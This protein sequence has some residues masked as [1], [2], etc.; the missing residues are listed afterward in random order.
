[1]HSD[2]S[3]LPDNDVK[4]RE[5]RSNHIEQ[6][7]A[8]P[9]YYEIT[10]I[11]HNQQP[12]AHRSDRPCLVTYNPTSQIDEKKIIKR[13]W[14]QHV[15]HDVRHMALLIHWFRFIQG[16]QRT[17]HCGAHTLVNSQETCLVSGLATPKQISAD[18]P[19]NDPKA[20]RSFNYYGSIMYRSD[21]NRA[22]AESP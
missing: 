5:T 10:Y 6:Y 17:W 4:P 12:W 11:M 15:V 3:V 22:T 7:G 21:F 1:M 8:R 18:Y 16:K 20:R 2:A 19:F 14:F 13:W 9:D